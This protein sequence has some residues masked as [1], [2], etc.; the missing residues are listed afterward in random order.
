MK[1]KIIFGVIWGCDAGGG[2]FLRVKNRF[3]SE[4]FICFKK[5]EISKDLDCRYCRG[6]LTTHFC[7]TMSSICITRPYNSIQIVLPGKLRKQFEDFESEFMVKLRVGFNW[8]QS[9][10]IHRF[11][12]TRYLSFLIYVGE[13]LNLFDYCS[14]VQI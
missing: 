6:R 7:K 5:K 3:P 8:D 14:Y 11:I 12:W 1:W 13:I 10:S 9:C 2:E 4:I